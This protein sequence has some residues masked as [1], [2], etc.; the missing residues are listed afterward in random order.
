[1]VEAQS[2]RRPSLNIS[3]VPTL[4]GVCPKP[5]QKS[6]N[7]GTTDRKVSMSPCGPD[8]WG[9]PV[10]LRG[11]T[12]S[13]Q[14]GKHRTFQNSSLPGMGKAQ[15]FPWNL[16]RQHW[17]WIIDEWNHSK[18]RNGFD[19][20]VLIRTVALALPTGFPHHGSTDLSRG[21]MESEF[22]MLFLQADSVAYQLG[23]TRHTKI[24]YRQLLRNI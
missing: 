2:L 7:L 14:A 19:S 13:K 5:A 12:H 4:P 9:L 17:S 11:E 6:P 15:G 16:R 22:T 23:D 20:S 8:C 21:W 18:L 24:F 3:E 10:S 1:M